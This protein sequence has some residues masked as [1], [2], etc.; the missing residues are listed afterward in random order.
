MGDSSSHRTVWNLESKPTI[1]VFDSPRKIGAK[2]TR[3][4]CRHSTPTLPDSA[5]SILTIVIVVGYSEVVADNIGRDGGVWPMN[6]S[7]LH[8]GRSGTLAF[9]ARVLG[10]GLDR[11]SG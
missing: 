8:H 10:E 11:F 4:S 6:F 9:F 5:K 3:Q 7:A 2:F 1:H